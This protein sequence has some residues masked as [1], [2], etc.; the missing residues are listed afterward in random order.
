[1]TTRG[2]LHPT[3]LLTFFRIITITEAE[4]TF[5]LLAL[6]AACIQSVARHIFEEDLP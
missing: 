4:D 2:S 1:M 5:L 3:N 6:Q